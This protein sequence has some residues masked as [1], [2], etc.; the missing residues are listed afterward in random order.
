M[1]DETNGEQEREPM[2]L[3]DITGSMAEPASSRGGIS[4]RELAKQA[5]S[6]IVKQLEAE[7]SQ[8]EHEEDAGGVMTVVFSR[9][10]A[11]SIG[12]LSSQN[13][14]EKWRHIRWGGGTYIVPGWNT[15]I[16][17]Y[18]EEFGE[19]PPEQ[20][21]LLMAVILT[22][23]EAVDTDDFIQALDGVKGG[24]AVVVALLGFGDEHDRALAAYQRVAAQHRGNVEVFSFAE[25]TDPQVIAGRLLQMIE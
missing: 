16:D 25:E 19:V 20:R 6:A 7:D 23:G 9:G 14:E 12:D 2:L 1:S 15:L 24:V 5:V 17:T 13:L 18:T 8:A 11:E 21:P 3:L 10:E 22:D 4:R